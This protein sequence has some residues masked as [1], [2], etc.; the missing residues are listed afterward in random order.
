MQAQFKEDYPKFKAKINSFISDTQ[1]ETRVETYITLFDQ[2]AS[3]SPDDIRELLEKVPMFAETRNHSMQL[4][5]KIVQI[6]LDLKE[7]FA[8]E[9]EAL[10]LKYNYD[11]KKVDQEVADKLKES[12]QLLKEYERVSEHGR[13][14]IEASRNPFF[15]Q[16]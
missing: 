5:E 12:A 4:M 9:E 6:H 16:M 11:L 7:L 10:G 15:D 14:L 1:F 3:I 13:E 8:L 2:M